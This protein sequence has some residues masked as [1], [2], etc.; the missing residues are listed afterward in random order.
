MII[1]GKTAFVYDVEVFPNFFSVTI[2]NTESK[3]I[4]TYVIWDG[5]ND[6]PQIVKL[7]L[8][9]NIYFVGYNSMHYDK[10][11][12]S[13]IILNYQ[14]LINS[15]VWVVNSELKSFS[16]LVINSETSAPWSK[17]K[18]A[19]LYD[20][21]DLLA[22]KWSDKLRPSLKALQVTML[23][24][25]VEEYEGDFNLYLPQKDVEKLIAYNIN[26]V[27][28][29]EE[30]LYRCTNDI[31]LRLSIQEEYGIDVMNKDGVNLGMEIIKD[32]YLKETGLSWYQIKDLRSPCD[33][34]CFGEIIFPYIEFKT[35][36]LQQL[37]LDLKNHCSDPNDNTFERKFLLG[38]V[39]HTFGMG[40]LHSVNTPEAFEPDDNTVLFDDDVAF[41]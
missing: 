15:P 40:G 18:Y 32:R 26:D 5:C 11:I 29:T 20:D 3:N 35:P 23:Y 38:E 13:Y 6:M 9:K 36:E 39:E 28:S 27:E 4:K 1:K 34:L 33:N 14:K 16:D 21:L 17:Y 31:D 10:P 12:I 8:N 25:N 24:K 7:F 19:N 22:M 30:F 41:A 2:K 37:L